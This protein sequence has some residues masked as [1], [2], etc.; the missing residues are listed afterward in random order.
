MKWGTLFSLP[1]VYL[2]IEYEVNYK[3]DRFK[4]LSAITLFGPPQNLQFITLGKTM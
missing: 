3:D 2:P 1:I 4:M